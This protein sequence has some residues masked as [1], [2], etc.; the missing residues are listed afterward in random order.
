MTALS[1]TSFQNGMRSGKMDVRRNVSKIVNYKTNVFRRKVDE[2][3][4]NSAL[5]ILIDL[6]GS[7]GCDGKGAMAQK[8]TIA[9][10]EALAPLSVPLEVLGHDT[11][12]RYDL[13]DIIVEGS[14]K[15]GR[16][17]PLRLYQFKSFDDSL[18]AARSSMGMISRLGHGANADGDAILM[19][20]KRLLKRTEEKKILFVLSDGQPAYSSESR[21]IHQ[22]TRDAVQ[23]CTF[24][25]INVMGLGMLD[26]SVSQYYP[27][28]VTVTDMDEFGRV[29]IDQIVKLMTSSALPDQSL[30]IQ[31]KNKRG[32]VA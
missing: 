16:T 11:G 10:A 24:R 23:W 26:D 12:G 29:Y 5:T 2:T 21:C 7:M 4:L 22:Y 14:T 17:D 3:S 27:Q 19:S 18:S 28:Y 31:T 30:L 32:Q 25:G 1:R 8:I 15:Y 9:I 6:S 20:A 13:D